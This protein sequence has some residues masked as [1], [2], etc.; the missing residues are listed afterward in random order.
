MPHTSQSAQFMF[1]NALWRHAPKTAVV[2]GERAYTYKELDDMSSNLAA[3]LKA[4]G[5]AKQDRVAILLRNCVEYVVTDLAILK[6]GAAKVPLNEMLSM[7][8]VGYMVGHS[9]AKAM[10]VHSSL[11][12]KLDEAE[13]SNTDLVHRVEVDD[14]GQGVAEGNAEWSSVFSGESAGFEWQ[15]VGPD[16]TALILYTGGTTGRSKGVIH[17]HG[18]LMINGLTHIVH[19]EIAEDEKLLLTSPLPH[20]A[21]F[22]LQTALL[23]GATA[24]VHRKFDPQTVL[25]TISR[26][27]ITWTFMVPTMVYRVLD[28]Y[29]PDTH[30]IS[31][32]RTLIYGAAP[33]TKVR[34]QE[35]LDKFGP[36]LLQ[37]FGQTEVPNFATKLSKADHL[38]E[39]FLGSCGQ[40]IITCDVRIG[41]KNSEPLPFGEVGEIMARSPY[42]LGS[43]YNDPEKTAEVYAGEWILTGDV[44]YQIDTGHVFIVD[45]SKD[46]IISGGMNVYSSEVENVVQEHPGVNQVMVIGI[47]HGDWGEAVCAAVV[48]AEGG[49]DEDDL[50]A[51]CKQR[52]AAYKVPKTIEVVEEIPL[53]A[54]GKP[55]K[56]TLRARYWG[57]QTRQVN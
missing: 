30:D 24:Y 41:D 2:V 42:T 40:P 15:E 7:S 33:I 19:G 16:D 22:F 53:T 37:L 32:L 27:K 29:Q 9:G 56:K 4:A 23:Q 34:L 57:D 14:L 44:G 39:K 8:D 45:R 51:F 26:E 1:R 36:V 21:G 17:S 55:D 25:E 50:V 20:S 43:Y 28:A 38:N 49:L 52:L 47:P 48:P 5:V 18:A 46:M 6:L 3:H 11:L 12:D 35:V 54:Y 31:S 10:V 13:L